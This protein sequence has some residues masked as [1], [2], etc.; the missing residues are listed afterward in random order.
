MGRYETSSWPRSW[1]RMD[2]RDSSSSDSDDSK[3]EERRREKKRK[4]SR[5]KEE[6]AREKKHSKR[7]HKKKERKQERPREAK[8]SSKVEHGLAQAT[9]A[10]FIASIRK[11]QRDEVEKALLERP[12]LIHTRVPAAGDVAGTWSVVHEAVCHCPA[13]GEKMAATALARYV[14]TG[15][16]SVLDAVLKHCASQG[17]NLNQLAQPHGAPSALDAGATSSQGESAGDAET[18]LHEAAWR[19]SASAVEMLTGAGADLFVASASGLLPIHCACDR[20]SAVYQHEGGQHRFVPW[21]L[22]R[23]GELDTTGWG[24]PDVARRL[25]TDVPHAFW[26]RRC[27]PAPLGI[28]LEPPDGPEAISR[29]LA[30]YADL[31]DGHDPLFDD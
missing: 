4:R 13:T 2:G 11:G 19:G 31:D 16:L 21:L 28:V 3:E 9:V 27:D 15:A 1:R 7:K 14:E 26:R 23:M 29:P 12:E 6:R 20:R 24:Q 10:A 30:K 5:P 25:R 8:E 17:L 18:P 22:K